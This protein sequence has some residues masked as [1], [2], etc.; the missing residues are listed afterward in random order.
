MLQQEYH[1]QEQQYGLHLQRAWQ[2]SMPS[3]A[4][5]SFSTSIFLV[6][7]AQPGKGNQNWSS[8]SSMSENFIVH[9]RN[10]C[11]HFYYLGQLYNFPSTKRMLVKMAPGYFYFF[12]STYHVSLL[13]IERETGTEKEKERECDVNLDFSQTSDSKEILE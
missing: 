8:D 6:S 2:T 10:N 9:V 3:S 5:P 12:S 11:H 7:Q 4:K 1:T 13:L